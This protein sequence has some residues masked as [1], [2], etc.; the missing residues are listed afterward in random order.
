MRDARLKEILE[1][2]TKEDLWNFNQ[3]YAEKLAMAEHEIEILKNAKAEE[4]AEHLKESK[5]IQNAENQ[6]AIE[7]LEDVK[8]FV[9]TNIYII[10]ENSQ[11][12]LYDF[13]DQKISEL[14]GE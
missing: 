8:K 3:D 4:L 13:I 9:K 12:E 1:L 11:K 5:T 6:K 10:N 2:Y 14:K 7:C